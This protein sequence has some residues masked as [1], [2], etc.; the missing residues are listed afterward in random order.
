LIAECLR[1]DY[2]KVERLKQSKDMGYSLT[3]AFY[4]FSD[5]LEQIGAILGYQFW[6]LTNPFLDDG[7]LPLIGYLAFT[8]ST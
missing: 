2:Q 6:L 3:L 8:D 5:E 7:S 1:N 4:F